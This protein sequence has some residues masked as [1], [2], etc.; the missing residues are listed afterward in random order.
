MGTLAST[1]SKQITNNI[2]PRLLLITP[3]IEINPKN[4]TIV[5]ESFDLYN[6][7][8]R[9]KLT[10]LPLVYNI[11]VEKTIV[12]FTIRKNWFDSEEK[13]SAH[14]TIKDVIINS[15]EGND[16]NQVG[17][18]LHFKVYGKISIINIKYVLLQDIL[19][20]IGGFWGIFALA[21]QAISF[22]YRSYF[23]RADLLN[24]VFKFH[25]DDMEKQAEYNELEKL[26]NYKN[27]TKTD[28]ELQI[29][30]EKNKIEGHFD[31]R[32][33]IALQRITNDIEHSKKSIIYFK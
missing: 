20:E 25:E 23:L 29:I 7:D 12:K 10:G 15:V 16:P 6:L 28:V 14:Y 24:T 1:I 8:F 22:L 9:D 19:G 17:C 31:N 32:N 21:G 18:T 30:E 3:Q 33:N 13:D 26:D 5:S 4:P 27:R 11:I 2:Y